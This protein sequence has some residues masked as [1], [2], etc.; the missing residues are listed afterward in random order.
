MWGT[1]SGI[2]RGPH[3]ERGRSGPRALAR[4]SLPGRIAI[5]G[6]GGVDRGPRDTGTPLPPGRRGAAW[7]LYTP[8]KNVTLFLFMCPLPS[9]L[10]LTSPP[11]FPHSRNGT[12]RNQERISRRTFIGDPP[13]M[14]TEY[15]YLLFP[16]F[17]VIP[18]FYLVGRIKL[19]NDRLESGNRYLLK[20]NKELTEENHKLKFRIESMCASNIG[21]A[22]MRGGNIGDA[23]L[24]KHRCML[25]FRDFTLQ[26]KDILIC[27][28]CVDVAV[29]GLFENQL[30]KKK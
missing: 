24:Q 9:F 7:P 27:P 25:C 1:S 8:Q 19:E 15:L 30:E 22:Q 13:V 6:V 4:T 14:H 17:C 3:L 18:C 26:R 28:T 2:D 12:N 16:I 20:R 21:R 5:G 11:L 23:V 10:L 29:P